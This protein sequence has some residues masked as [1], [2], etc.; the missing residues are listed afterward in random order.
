[1][2]ERDMDAKSEDS[3]TTKDI[4]AS[5]DLQSILIMLEKQSGEMRTFFTLEMK[6]LQAS[7]D[8]GA[9]AV[10]TLAELGITQKASFDEAIKSFRETQAEQ[11]KF[12]QKTDQ[13]VEKL[14]SAVD[15]MQAQL[16]ALRLQNNADCSEEERS[17]KAQKTTC[18]KGQAA[19]P[20]QAARASSAE[21]TR[22]REATSQADY[23]GGDPLTAHIVLECEV[24][25]SRLHRGV[26][27]LLD[28]V[29]PANEWF[30]IKAKARSAAITFQNQGTCTIF[31]NKMKERNADD[32]P[33]HTISI[34]KPDEVGIGYAFRCKHDEPYPVRRRKF[35]SARVWQAVQSLYK[36]KN[37]DGEKLTL[38]TDHLSGRLSAEMADYRVKPILVVG[39][40][41]DNGR[42]A[43]TALPA[44]LELTGFDDSCIA[45]IRQM[46]DK[47]IGP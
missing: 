29:L 42:H 5:S 22:A 2:S 23:N 39:T 40:A 30:H 11:H 28:D 41:D 6:S 47:E 33:V 31:V 37:K 21:P 16:A 35:V 3:R 36:T 7:T 19:S 9:E 14:K 43:I 44:L 32:T 4:A 17:R 45:I 24:M 25:S 12:N 38:K 46:V 27:M 34:G 8:R 20:P 13:A 1:M 26:K 18:G 15:D 10:A